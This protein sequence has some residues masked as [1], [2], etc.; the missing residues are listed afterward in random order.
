M[1]EGE[2]RGRKGR[3]K[4]LLSRVW[5]LP[6]VRE[7]KNSS[8]T[9]GHEACLAPMRERGSPFPTRK[10]KVADTWELCFPLVATHTGSRS[11]EQS[12]HR[13]NQVIWRP[14]TVGWV[15]GLCTGYLRRPYAVILAQS[16]KT[17]SR[18]KSTRIKQKRKEKRFPCISYAKMI[19]NH[20]VNRLLP[21]P[22][23]HFF[24]QLV[25]L[26]L[27]CSCMPAV[28]RVM[29]SPLVPPTPPHATLLL[30]PRASSHTRYVRRP[31]N[32]RSKRGAVYA[33]SLARLRKRGINREL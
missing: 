7:R 12:V 15:L 19:Y 33:I 21:L 25:A 30:A 14:P 28:T 16:K 2:Q 31:D 26:W 13:R 27:S 6:H 10:T 32:Y 24:M 18:H 23:S 8:H 22:L 29:M 20:N 4:D 17:K 11:L 1:G 3:A 5:C 9:L